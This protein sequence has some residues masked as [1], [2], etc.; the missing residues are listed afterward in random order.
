[1]LAGSAD[2]LF[3]PYVGAGFSALEGCKSRG[4]VVGFSEE[5][6]VEVELCCFGL[7]GNALD[8]FWGGLVFAFSSAFS[9]AA[10]LL[11]SL[12]VLALSI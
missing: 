5:V 6:F 8:T 7:S 10:L 12:L 2:P 9:L 4:G 3:I 11:T 1:M